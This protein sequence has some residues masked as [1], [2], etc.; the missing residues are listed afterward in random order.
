[1]L[2]FRRNILNCYF[3]DDEIFYS[4]S[5]ADGRLYLYLHF[6]FYSLA[7]CISK[8]KIKRVV[9]VNNGFFYWFLTCFLND[10]ISKRENIAIKII[11]L[12]DLLNSFLFLNAYIKRFVHFNQWANIQLKIWFNRNKWFWIK[13]SYGLT[14]YWKQL[15]SH[16]KLLTMRSKIICMALCTFQMLF[17]FHR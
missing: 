15:N 1:M 4:F 5:S 16:E 2:S 3:H 10:I 6:Q 9:D 17:F 13:S 7:N 8:D 12:R 14:K 11:F